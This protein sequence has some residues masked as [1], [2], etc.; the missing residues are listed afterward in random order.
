MRRRVAASLRFL[1]GDASAAE[2]A[3]CRVELGLGG[4]WGVE[5]FALEGHA[6]KWYRVPTGKSLDPYVIVSR[7]VIDV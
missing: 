6:P 5:C 3:D 7:R 1:T 2:M 4:R